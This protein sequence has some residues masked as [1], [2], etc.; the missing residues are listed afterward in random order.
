MWLSKSVSGLFLKVTLSLFFVLGKGS[1]YTQPTSRRG[2]VCTHLLGILLLERFVPPPLIHL[3]S[4][5][6]RLVQTRGYLFYT[7]AYNP[8]F[9]C[10]DSS[11]WNSFRRSHVPLGHTASLCFCLFA[12]SY[13]FWHCKM[14]QFQYIICSISRISHFL[15]EP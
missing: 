12:L 9:C 1:H 10:L 6:F 4:Y 2:A 5:L 3:L 14:L 15:K 8:L 7:S 11:S 13:S